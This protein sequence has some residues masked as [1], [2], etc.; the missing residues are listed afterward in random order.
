MTL[1]A[2]YAAFLGQ[3]L[4][5]WMRQLAVWLSSQ[6]MF[7]LFCLTILVYLAKA[8]RSLIGR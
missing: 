8:I 3:V 5:A 7:I 4:G 2:A 6:P 1:D